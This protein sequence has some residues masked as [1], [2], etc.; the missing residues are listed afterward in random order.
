MIIPILQ[1]LKLRLRELKVT[2]LRHD[3]IKS[4]NIIF[5]P[6]ERVS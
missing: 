1:K 3:W 6:W 5:P 2:Q 4:L